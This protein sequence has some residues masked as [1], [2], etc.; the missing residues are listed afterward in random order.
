VYDWREV[1]V[2]NGDAICYVTVS[3][4]K[5]IMN[6]ARVLIVEAH[7]VQVVTFDSST[8]EE[9]RPEGT[10]HWLH[11]PTNLMVLGDAP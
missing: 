6:L 8:D 1:E 7:R 9:Q 2:K 3:G 10:P 11:E 4:H 5:P